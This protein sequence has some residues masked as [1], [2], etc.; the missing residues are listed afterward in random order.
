[1]EFCLRLG[2]RKKMEIFS[3]SSVSVFYWLVQEIERLT[4]SALISVF[5]WQNI[6]PE[7]HNEYGIT[8][9]PFPTYCSNASRT[10]QWNIMIASE[11]NNDDDGDDDTSIWNAENRG[12]EI[13]LHFVL[14]QLSSIDQE[15]LER[16]F[17]LEM[18]SIVQKCLCVNQKE[19]FS[20][21]SYNV[22]WFSL[23]L[24]E[25]E[26]GGGEKRKQKICILSQ[27]REI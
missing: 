15:L 21:F 19:F 8:P 24:S 4:I 17:C 14:L 11:S 6:F 2:L 3:L 1:M 27:H 10:H 18:N 5:K 22:Y 26:R 13:D 12:N 16:K 25:R 9:L 23:S 7:R 20:F